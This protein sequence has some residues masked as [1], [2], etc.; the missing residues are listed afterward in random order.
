MKK[1]WGIFAIKS[2]LDEAIQILKNKDL[3]IFEVREVTF[4]EKFIYL[5]GVDLDKELWIVMFYATEE[6]YE[7]VVKQN[8]ME[9]VLTFDKD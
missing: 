7:D 9:K 2:E 4:M 5:K 1:Q 8:N 3:E 6:E